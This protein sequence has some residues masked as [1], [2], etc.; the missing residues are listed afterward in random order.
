MK[1][2]WESGGTASLILNLGTRW[3]WVVSSTPP[4]LYAQEKSPWYLL[5][6]RMGGTQS[7]S[8]R[9]SEEKNSQPLQGLEHPEH[10]VHIP[11]P[12]IYHLVILALIILFNAK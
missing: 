1:V 7:Q 12:A 4:L 11:S 5:G 2:Y 10:P 9:G 3:R 6:R 8:E